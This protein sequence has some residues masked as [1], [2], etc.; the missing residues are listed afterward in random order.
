MAY[1]HGR[2]RRRRRRWWRRDDDDDNQF[3]WFA[4][5]GRSCDASRQVF[6]SIQHSRTVF[7]TLIY[8]YVNNC[9]SQTVQ[10][11]SFTQLSVSLYAHNRRSVNIVIKHATGRVMSTIIFTMRLRQFGKKHKTTQVYTGCADKFFRPA[12]GR[13]GTRRTGRLRQWRFFAE[14]FDG[15]TTN[16]YERFKTQKSVFGLLT[17]TRV[18]ARPP[19]SRD[20]LRPGDTILIA[21]AT[22]AGTWN[23]YGAVSFVFFVQLPNVKSFPKLPRAVSTDKGALV[24]VQNLLARPVHVIHAQLVVRRATLRLSAVSSTNNGGNENSY[25]IDTT[26]TPRPRPRWIRGLPEAKDAQQGRSLILIGT[27]TWAFL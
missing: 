12:H 17:Y 6:V 14:P 18:T 8:S 5:Y 2:R 4:V 19:W 7:S 11:T 15:F 9:M 10:Q 1:V 23:A 20:V 13:A 3:G 24:R 27:S 26:Q 25:N 21:T 16:S 22:T